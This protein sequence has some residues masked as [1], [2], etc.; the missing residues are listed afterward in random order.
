MNQIT[1]P[2]LVGDS[3]LAILAAIGTLRLVRDFVDDQSRLRW[4][5]LD[6]S[7]VLESSLTSVDEVVA[8]LTRIVDEETPDGVLVPG[9]PRDFPPPGA[10]PDRL[11]V[12][13][14][15]LYR[16]GSSF[17]TN[18]PKEA[19]TV[20]G[21]LGSLVTDLALDS[22]GKVAI[23]QY[24]A[25]AGGQS[26]GTMLA[27][28][29]ELVRSTP[30]YLRQALT[31]WRR[32]RGV[33]GEYLD[34]RAVWGSGDDGR[35]EPQMR[36]VPGA[37]WLALMSYPLWT[38]TADSSHPH[39]SGW[40][41]FPEGRRQRWELRLPLWQEPLGPDAV[42]ALVEHPALAGGWDD[43]DQGMLRLLGIVHVCR[44]RRWPSPGGKSAGVL[45]VVS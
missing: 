15:E 7:P 5:P 28:P 22:K 1:F 24:T 21:W 31:G 39:S 33:T 14:D 6:R 29:L 36:G 12:P 38:T 17:F 9:G 45:A 42:K 25:P 20:R 41:R 2:A 35:G 23:S 10:S 4:D 11:R 44:A 32:V 13:P 18:Q 34:S 3:P 27:K 26:M 43:V 8:E 30:D 16:L 37:T 40:H 19:A